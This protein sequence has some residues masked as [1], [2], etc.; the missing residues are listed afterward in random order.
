MY[1]LEKYNFVPTGTLISSAILMDHNMVLSYD[2]TKQKRRRQQTNAPPLRPF[3]M[4]MRRL[5]NLNF[6]FF[7]FNPGLEFRI[8]LK[9]PPILTI[10]LPCSYSH[11]SKTYTKWWST[12][13]SYPS[14][15]KRP[16]TVIPTLLC[17]ELGFWV[18][19]G[20]KILSLRHGWGWQPPQTATPIHIAHTK[21]LTTLIGCPLAYSSNLTQFYPS[22]FPQIMGFLGHLCG[23]KLMS[24]RHAGH[25]WGWHP[26]ETAS[27]FHIRH[28][29]SVGAHWYDVHWHTAV[30][31]HSY[32]HPTCLRF[33]GFV[34]LVKSKWCNFIMVEADRHLKLLPLSI[35][36]MY[37]ELST[38]ICCPSSYI[39][40]L[41]QL[42]PPYLAWIFGF[43][44]TCTWME[45]NLCKPNFWSGEI[46]LI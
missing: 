11:P 32:T 40:S 15:Y 44:V 16:Y 37:K 3:P 12:L 29:Q 2:Y 36:D 4:T 39:S 33:W 43:W 45:S 23:V 22:Y 9:A 34:P 8:C 31:L 27:P 17:S 5:R 10:F 41:T 18:T 24:L 7:F 20:G 14:A 1:L 25:G 26:P 13:I 21:C 38:L 42:Y 6:D 19:C 30:A 35:L 46:Y 28:I